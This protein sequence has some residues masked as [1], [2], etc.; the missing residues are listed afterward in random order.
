MAQSFDPDMA[1]R[2]QPAAQQIEGNMR[3]IIIKK[4]WMFKYCHYQA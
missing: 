2:P 4:R 3:V 1:N